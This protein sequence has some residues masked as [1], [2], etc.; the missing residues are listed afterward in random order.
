MT[1]APKPTGTAA[2]AE[3]PALLTLDQLQRAMPYAG[4][5][6][7]LYLSPLCEAMLEYGINT[8][9]R[10]AHFIAQLAHES[11]SLRY[12]RELASGAA[13]EG[14]ADLGNTQPG[15]GPRYKGRGLIQIT[16]RANYYACS[17]ALYG[18]TRLITR[19]EL[20]ED[21]LPACRSAAWFWQ[22]RNLSAHADTGDIR[23]ITRAINGGYNGFADR[24][25]HYTRACQALG[26]APAL[27]AR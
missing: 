20:L 25:E 3:P 6:A 16:G 24:L 2:P 12:T 22:T 7:R 15:D 1:A 23:R 26:I 11:G 10:V 14:R 8:P 4:P 21:I 9:R 18:D 5:R 19:P 17:R 27:I 13:Y